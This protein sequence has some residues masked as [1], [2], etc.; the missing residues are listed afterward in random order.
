M[1]RGTML[2]HWILENK[3]SIS[4]RDGSL[5]PAERVKPV[6]ALASTAPAEATHPTH[7]RARQQR[8]PCERITIAPHLSHQPDGTQVRTLWN[9]NCLW[10]TTD[11]VLSHTR[12]S[13]ATF[14]STPFAFTLCPLKFVCPQS[15]NAAGGGDFWTPACRAE[16]RRGNPMSKLIT[17][18]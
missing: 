17:N 13:V 12:H 8:G 9:P 1:L 6:H 15:R 18:V 5:H 16:R 4:N 14:P 7:W 2:I 11:L 10:N 3:L